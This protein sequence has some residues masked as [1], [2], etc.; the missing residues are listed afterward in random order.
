RPR[1]S[2]FLAQRAPV[3]A[4]G[5]AKAASCTLRQRHSLNSRLS[6]ISG[7]LLCPS[8]RDSGMTTPDWRRSLSRCSLWL[9]RQSDTAFFSPEGPSTLAA[10]ARALAAER[11]KLTATAMLLLAR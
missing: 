6:R 4:S 10:L 1:A 9:A 8:H 11:A 5:G 7:P 3:P 2:A